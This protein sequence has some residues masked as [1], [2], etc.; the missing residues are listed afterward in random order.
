MKLNTKVK[1]WVLS[2]KYS[3]GANYSEF[4]GAKALFHLLEMPIP[5]KERVWPT[6]ALKPGRFSP[7][8]DNSAVDSRSPP[9]LA[10]VRSHFQHDTYCSSPSLYLK[11]VLPVYTRRAGRF[12]LV[13]NHNRS[14]F[15]R[16]A[17]HSNETTVF[18]VPSLFLY[19]PYKGVRLIR[20][21]AAT[22][23]TR[24]TWFITH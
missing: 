9:F 17:K 10:A 13:Q 4:Q 23:F 7:A 19:K 21:Y 3:G 24:T 5:Q 6:V 22:T 14:G 2:F 15:S 12:V 1:I 8:I 18:H 16:F 20:V 11:P